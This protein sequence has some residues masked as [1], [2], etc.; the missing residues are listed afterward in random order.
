MCWFGFCALIGYLFGMGEQ[1]RRVS[2]AYFGEEPQEMGNVVAA[3]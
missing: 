3:L 1:K 2:S